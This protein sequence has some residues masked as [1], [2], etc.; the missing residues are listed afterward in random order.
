M[1][2]QLD[3]QEADLLRAIEARYDGDAGAI[4]TDMDYV[5]SRLW[6]CRVYTGDDFQMALYSSSSL[7]GWLEALESMARQLGFDDLVLE[8]EAA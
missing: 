2:T 6:R 7:G 8:A 4:R 3:E 1:R 5:G